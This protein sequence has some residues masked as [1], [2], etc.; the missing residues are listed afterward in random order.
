MEKV[1]S[2]DRIRI[3]LFEDPEEMKTILPVKEFV[4]LS[5]HFQIDTIDSDKENNFEG[6]KSRLDFVAPNDECLSLL[7]DCQ[8]RLGDYKISYVE[9]A[10]DKIAESENDAEILSKHFATTT[11]K[12]W[13]SNHFIYDQRLKDDFPKKID[14]NKFGKMTLYS[15]SNKFGI[16]SYSRY[17]KVNHLP[18]FHREYIVRTPSAI[19]QKTGIKGLKDFLFFDFPNFFERTDKIYLSIGIIDKERLG[20]YLLGW[21]KKKIFTDR[22]IW[23]LELTSTLYSY[24]R[25]AGDL[26]LY[27]QKLK[28]EIR[29]KRGPLTPW[30]IRILGLKNYSRI[31]RDP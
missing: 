2:F 8:N 12:K 16:R 26:I 13:L 31:L 23:T 30:D 10:Q 9:I 29:K 20:R 22:E 14:P 27:I 4:K 3:N 15:R 1:Y 5:H 7:F 11:R 24:E 21:S 6:Y 28:R 18:A 17:S 25:T 19:L